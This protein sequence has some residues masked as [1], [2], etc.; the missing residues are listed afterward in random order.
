MSLRLL[1]FFTYYKK[2][3]H[4]QAAI[5]ELEQ[6]IKTS[7]PS[8]LERSAPWYK[9]WQQ[10]GIQQNYS[11]AVDL[12]K[13]FE[14]CH[15]EAYAD[16]LH[17]WGVPT[18]GYGT[19]RYPNGNK[20]AKGDKITVVEAEELLNAEVNSI[21]STLKRTIPHWSAMTLEQQCA[22][23]DFGYNLGSGFYGA[24]GFETIT[25]K[26]QAK[27]WGAVPAAMLL[28]CNPGT[29]VE[30]GLRRRRE[31]EGALWRRGM[32]QL[33]QEPAK[34]NPNSPFS[35]RLTPHIRLGEFA[36]D[37]EAR[38]FD[39][40]YQVDTAAE[41]AAFLE[42]VRRNFGDKPIVITSGYRP[43]SI[44]KQV[45]GASQ[46]EHLFNAPGVGAVDFFVNGADIHA[47]QLFCDKYW[48]YS[49]GYGAPKGFIHVGIRQGR[50]RA[51]WD[52]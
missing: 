23:I 6:A 9:T 49:V 27:D 48:N 14:G 40:Q 13:E 33:Q 30:A 19:T 20:V 25:A 12:I 5:A 37:Q 52:Y 35:A 29:D 45:G 24:E 7:A 3:P 16:P 42:R 2:L 21:A 43:P 18:I 50:P 8:L 32:A 38:R 36:L 1:D 31:A 46:S 41:L 51:R 28:Y 47:V 15:L 26:L 44:N 10:A 39:H 11:Q 22:L 17:G 34:L 4:Q